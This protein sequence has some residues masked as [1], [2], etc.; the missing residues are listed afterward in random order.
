MARAR[1]FP[2]IRPSSR[3]YNPGNYPQTE[4]VAQNG[5]RTVIRYG[6]RRTDSELSLSFNNITDDQAA[7]IMAHFELVNGRWDWVTFTSANGT[8]G[9]SSS[10]QPYL[11]ESASGLRWRYAEPPSL[12]SVVPGRSTVSCKFVGILDGV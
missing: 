6:S 1:P 3:S 4:F 11:Q 10:L 5:S 2:A 12:Q 7:S 8:V 9:A